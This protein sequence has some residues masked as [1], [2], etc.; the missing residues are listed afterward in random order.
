V[1]GSVDTFLAPPTTEI[2]RP[3]RSRW[4]EEDDEDDSDRWQAKETKEDNMIDRAS[5]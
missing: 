5:L 4:K 3:R 2:E 1:E